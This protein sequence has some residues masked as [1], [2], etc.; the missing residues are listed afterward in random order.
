MNPTNAMRQRADLLTDM[1]DAERAAEQA[2]ANQ[3]RRAL[4]VL[5]SD[6]RMMFPGAT[7]VLVQAAGLPDTCWIDVVYG[8]DAED[9]L[10]NVRGASVPFADDP[11]EPIDQAMTRAL[12]FTADPA[13]VPGWQES[14]RRSGWYVVDFAA[15]STSA[16]VPVVSTVADDELG[17]GGSAPRPTGAA[18]SSGDYRAKAPRLVTEIADICGEFVDAVE[19]MDEDDWVEQAGELGRIELAFLLGRFDDA[20]GAVKTLLAGLTAPVERYV[21]D[22]GLLD[23]ARDDLETAEES[24]SATTRAIDPTNARATILHL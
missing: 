14:D 4:L 7:G 12:R 20:R 18:G 16:S 24:L 23:D 21:G 10:W 11:L 3:V 22:A 5:Y 9:E 2:V 1:E 15:L 8:K 13:T 17:G 19:R 6:I